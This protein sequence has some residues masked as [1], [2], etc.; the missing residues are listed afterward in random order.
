MKAWRWIFL[1]VLLA[2]LAAFGWHW[3]AVDPGQVLITL[4]GW[5]LQTTVLTAVVVVIV[6]VLVLFWTWRL[7]RWPF[8]ALTRRHR[9]VC[10]QQLLAGLVALA[11][12]RHGDAGRV[13]AKA[14]RYAPQ[15]GVAW[16][17]AARAC[18]ASGDSQASL[19]ALDKA[20]RDLPRAARIERARLLRVAGRAGEAVTLLAPE[21]DAGKLL[22][23]GW[24]ELLE[25]AMASG[26][27]QRALRALEPLRKSGM[28]NTESQADVE[29]RVLV[30]A[31]RATV[32][33]AAL[34]DL[35]SSLSRA[36]RRRPQVI[37]AYARRAAH[38][39]QVMAAMHEL[40][41]ALR[42]QWSPLL[43]ETWGVLDDEDIEARLRK[44][45]GWLSAHR[46]DA[47]L[48]STLGRLCVRLEVW[49]KAREYLGRSLAL[50]PSAIAWE[51]MGDVYAGQDNVLL[52]QRCYHNALRLDRGE[53]IEPLPGSHAGSAE[54]D[55]PV[56]VERNEHGL[57][58]ISSDHAPR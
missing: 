20:A 49:G 32:D 10:R 13:L 23:A 16:L 45:E 36:R 34:K 28:L 56:D 50:Q 18:A 4:R 53:P 3:I 51:A 25:A 22:P 5:R 37:A 48:L 35:W 46:D 29:V 9:R 52:S 12:G 14:A 58:H 39:G 24:Y 44:A 33:G 57:P 38:F 6:V 43:V 47:V 42:R 55:A 1:L 19:D 27:P 31:I 11:E 40:E 54:A 21:A 15:R 30:A 2:V 17:A 7:L 26:D 41:S 8:G